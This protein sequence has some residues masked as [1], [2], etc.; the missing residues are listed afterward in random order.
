MKKE[1]WMYANCPAI[2]TTQ[3]ITLKQVFSRNGIIYTCNV[4]RN[5]HFESL[6]KIYNLVVKLL[7]EFLIIMSGISLC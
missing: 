6:I 1:I 7:T 2:K 5:K 4:I 3:D